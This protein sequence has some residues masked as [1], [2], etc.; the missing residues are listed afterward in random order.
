M[1]APIGHLRP[2][3]SG[4]FGFSHC[5]LTVYGVRGSGLRKRKETET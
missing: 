1:N 3:E 5:V 2:K 4:Q